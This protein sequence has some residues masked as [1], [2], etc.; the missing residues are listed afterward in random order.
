MDLKDLKIFSKY[1][2]AKVSP[3]LSDKVLNSEDS[4][5]DNEK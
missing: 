2:S 3:S 5:D 1:E 4:E